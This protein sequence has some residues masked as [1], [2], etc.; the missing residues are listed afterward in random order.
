MALTVEASELQE[1]FQWLTAEEA[2]DVKYS[3][4]H[5]AEEIAD[6]FLYLVRLADVLNIDLKTAVENKLEKNSQKYPAAGS[7]TPRSL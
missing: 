7:K 3:S 1:I 6:I 5:A 4:D 2:T